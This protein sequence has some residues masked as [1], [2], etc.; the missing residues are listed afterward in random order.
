MEL[1]LAN[2]VSF[3]DLCFDG[4]VPLLYASPHNPGADKMAHDLATRFRPD[5]RPDVSLVASNAIRRGL[6]S[7][8]NSE[9]N[10][11]DAG[12]GL[13]EPSSKP[14]DGH[15]FVLYL[16][17]RTWIGEEGLMLANEVSRYRMYTYIDV[18][19]YRKRER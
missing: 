1:C 19:M 16:T 2:E 9:G 15:I 6:R 12:L 8:R 17:E 4:I 10:G 13:T 11:G 18:Y 5:E 14:A 7:L 3:A